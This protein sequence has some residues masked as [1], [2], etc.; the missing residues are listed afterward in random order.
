MV[1]MLQ[2][3]LNFFYVGPKILENQKYRIFFK[4]K[5]LFFEHYSNPWSIY[6]EIKTLC[7][8]AYGV[9]KKACLKCDINDYEV[10][11]IDFGCSKFKKKKIF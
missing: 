1:N 10:K 4:L 7:K 5:N 3:N 2:W 11:L 6:T 8:G 9:I